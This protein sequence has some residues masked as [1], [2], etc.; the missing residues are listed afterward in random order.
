M[1]ED[2]I[3]SFRAA[4]SDAG[5][6]PPE[7]ID[8]DGQRHRFSTNGKV[9]DDAGWYVLY[10]DGIPAGAYG[11]WRQQISRTWSSRK[12]SDVTPAEREAYEHKIAECKRQ[13]DAER[14][15]RHAEARAR[16][17]GI[18]Q[19]ARPETGEHRY[20]REKGVGAYGIR[21]D[22]LRLIVPMRDTR[23]R[24]H[25]LQFILPDGAKRCLSGGHVSGCY[26]GIGKPSG[27]LCVAEG[28]AI[29]A[30][31]YEATGQAVAVAFDADRL[32]QVAEALRAKYPNLQLL[33]CADNDIKPDEPNRGIEQARKAALA[34]G[35]LTAV[36][37]MDGEKCDFNDLHRKRGAQ[38]VRDAIANAKPAAIAR[39]FCALG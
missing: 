35:G 7:A 11:C 22:G 38:A 33:V 9:G 15:R 20:L 39:A 4:I 13:R 30:S 2:I 29:A 26:H 10:T 32:K 36:P 28:Y 18:W 5:I 27:T 17:E 16:A 21:T 3:Q 6:E 25:S 24:L 14:E 12:P 23:G 19:E 1:M 34:V 8:A 31:I 37:E